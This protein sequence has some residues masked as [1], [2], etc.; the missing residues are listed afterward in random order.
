MTTKIHM[1][2]A[3]ACEAVDFSLS[4]GNAHDDPQGRALLL[5]R[6][7]CGNARP[8]LMDKAYQG[9]EIRRIAR[10]LKY[11]PTVPPRANRK[12]PWAIDRQLY[13]RRNEIERLFRRVKG[14]RRIFTRYDK[15]DVIFQGFIFFVLSVII[16]YVNTP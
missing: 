11:T 13:R 9:D 10:R 7:R 6:G 15:L 8:L 1:L 2:G 4:A 14:Y 16:L 5:R 3:N 12:R